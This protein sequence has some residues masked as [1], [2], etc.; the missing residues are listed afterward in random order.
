MAYTTITIGCLIAS[1]VSAETPVVTLDPALPYRAQRG[2]PVTYQVD[3][4]VIVTPPAKTKK[5]KVW[6]PLPA[7][8]FGQ[9]VQ[10][11]K[12]GTL[13]QTVQPRVASEDVYG[14]TFAYFEFAD[15]QGAQLIR[16]QFQVKVWELRWDLDASKIVA[17]D[18]WPASF[19]RYRRSE[20]QA[21]VVN[22]QIGDLLKQILPKRTTPLADMS[23]ILTW[24]NDNLQYDHGQASLKASS[25]HA[26]ANRRGHCSDYHGFCA[27]LGRALGY[28][29]RIT[30]GLHAFSKASPSHC[31]LEVFLPPYGWVSFDVSET[32]RM[33]AAIAGNKDLD[34]P[35][36]RQLAGTAHQ[37]M[38]AG[39]RDNTWFVQTRGS[40]YELAPPASQR[41]SVVRTIYAEADGVA[42]PDPD[43]SNPQQREF[44]WMT[45]VQFKADRQV[46]Y[47][48]QDTSTLTEQ[49]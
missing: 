48:F 45:V 11:R 8:D 26:L 24:V 20:S 29:T 41:V 38:L 3:Y 6:L 36:R 39:F 46:T 1:I 33:V 43:P 42:L 12:L 32:Q 44:A 16:H 17:V 5:L 22:Q 28:P 7:S 37:R 25:L 14:N 35:R 23:S 30:Y 2:D 34:E 49:P 4:Q 15:P 9:E 27:S 10:G 31:K 18:E 40:D 47:P 21:V 19:E 13:P